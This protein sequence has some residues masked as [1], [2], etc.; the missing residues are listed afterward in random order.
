MPQLVYFLGLAAVPI[1]D[2]RS[3]G[4]DG[5][6]RAPALCPCWDEFVLPVMTSALAGGGGGGGGGGGRAVDFI[7]HGEPCDVTVTASLPC[8]PV[9]ASLDTAEDFHIFPSAYVSYSILKENTDT[10]LAP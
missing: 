8:R 3:S 6:G 9:S 7:Q 2:C 10:Q 5:Q 4:Q 1:L